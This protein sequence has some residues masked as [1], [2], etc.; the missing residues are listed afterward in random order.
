MLELYE[1]LIVGILLRL[2]V[3]SLLRFRCVSKFW[4]D[5]ID[6]K[7]FINMHYQQSINSNTNFHLLFQISSNKLCS[8]SK[9]FDNVGLK[10]SLTKIDIPMSR[11][12]IGSRT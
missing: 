6:N 8:C 5:L 11:Q 2:S 9:Y 10:K 7:Y 4:R 1:E 3:K 12:T